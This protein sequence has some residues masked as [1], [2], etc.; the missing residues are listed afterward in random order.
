[1]Y[2]CAR[3]WTTTRQTSSK[4]FPSLLCSSFSLSLFT[5]LIMA[6]VYTSFFML[7]TDFDEIIQSA[8]IMED[9]I[10]GINGDKRNINKTIQNV[11]VSS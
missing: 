11:K 2:F 6:M 5:T 1:M 10:N 9:A 4:C 8:E 3:D 7:K